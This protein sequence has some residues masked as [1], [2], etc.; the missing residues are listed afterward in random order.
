MCVDQN[1]P[2]YEVSVCRTNSLPV[3]FLI[4]LIVI[5]IDFDIRFFLLP[6]NIDI[7]LSAIIGACGDLL[8]LPLTCF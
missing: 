1:F 2:N 3:C 8:S 5:I 6:P 7:T 4:K